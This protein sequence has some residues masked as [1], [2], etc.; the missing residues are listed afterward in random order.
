MP[1][2]GASWCIGFFERHCCFSSRKDWFASLVVNLEG[3]GGGLAF[4]C[5]YCLSCLHQFESCLQERLNSVV[6]PHF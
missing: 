2:L 3:G 6:L 1:S 4:V 5:R